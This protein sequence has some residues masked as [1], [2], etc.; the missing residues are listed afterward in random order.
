MQAIGEHL[1]NSKKMY[2]QYYRFKTL[3]FKHTHDLAN[4]FLS[5][6]Y[7][8]P[9]AVLVSGLD[10]GVVLHLL[11]GENGTGKTFFIHYVYKHI[12]HGCTVAVINKEIESASMLLKLTLSGFG[13]KT[14]TSKNALLLLQLKQVLESQLIENHGQPSLLIIDDADKISP[15]V[16]S[17]IDQLLSL[18]RK[19]NLLLQIILVGNHKLQRTINTAEMQTLPEIKKI[20]WHRITPLTEQETKNYIQHQ[21]KTAG[22]SDKN[23]FDEDA[24]KEIYQQSKGNIKKINSICNKALLL[25]IKLELKQIGSAQISEITKTNSFSTHLSSEYPQKQKALSFVPVKEGINFAGV[26]LTVYLVSAPFIFPTK[27]AEIDQIKQII[28]ANRK[29]NQEILTTAFSR[30]SKIDNNPDP[31][32]E[33]IALTLNSNQSEQRITKTPD[34]DQKNTAEFSKKQPIIPEVETLLA[35]AEQQII[36]SRLLTPENDNAYQ[37]FQQILSSNPDEK[38]AI[39]GLHLI[40]NRY[41]E[42]S[43]KHFAI[44]NLA[45]SK[46]FAN[47]GLSVEPGHQKLAYLSKKIDTKIARKQQLIA[48]LLE[49]GERQM[50]ASNL[51]PPSSKNAYQFFLDVLALDNTNKQAKKNIN[52]IQAKLMSKLDLTTSPKN[53]HNARQLSKK[54]LSTTL[55]EHYLPDAFALASQTDTFFNNKISTLLTRASDQINLRQLF[56]P[57]GNNAVESLHEILDIDKNHNLAIKKLNY[58]IEIEKHSIEKT[59]SDARI[60]QALSEINMLVKL[61]PTEPAL[62]QLQNKISFALN[63]HNLK[64][65]ALNHSKKQIKVKKQLRPFGNF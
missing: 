39:A 30:F 36:Q 24:C 12:Q 1:E 31:A 48:S 52:T 61:F 8:I 55:A 22:R 58:I 7:E 5:Q 45:Q 59:L 38:R 27:T 15:K 43:E 50:A 16:L 25:G 54:I 64:I 28:E 13:I 60:N 62:L 14:R 57:A 51:I 9:L 29:S 26:A 6:N 40:A 19:D 44:G 53:Y 35:K 56:K 4:I 41:L 3:P 17:S 65:A 33:E 47:R 34:P 11:I 20:L 49:Q 46:R 42:L 10:K 63:E 21:L 2:K 23:L 32:N 18:N 37:T